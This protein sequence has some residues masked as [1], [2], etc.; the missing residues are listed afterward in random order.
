MCHIRYTHEPVTSSFVHQASFVKRIE[1]KKEK[2]CRLRASDTLV[3]LSKQTNV[4]TKQTCDYEGASITCTLEHVLSRGK[5][6]LFPL[7]RCLLWTTSVRFAP[8]NDV[9]P[10][11]TAPGWCVFPFF[12]FFSSFHARNGGLKA[13]CST[14]MPGSIYSELQQKRGRGRN[15]TKNSLADQRAAR[16]TKR[17][18]LWFL[19][20]F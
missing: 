17:P 18:K 19:V 2:K 14:S 12:F 5:S 1:G 9:A 6:L 16:F 4:Q 15:I 8:E 7:S 13:L 11:A 3:N 20:T 10:R